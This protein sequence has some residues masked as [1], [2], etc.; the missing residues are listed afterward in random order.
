MSRADKYI[1]GLDMDSFEHIKEISRYNFNYYNGF[2]NDLLFGKSD[3]DNTTEWW[4][5][6][7]EVNQYLGESHCSDDEKLIRYRTRCT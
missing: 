3:D 2:D 4:L 5:I 6:I 1:D 7:G